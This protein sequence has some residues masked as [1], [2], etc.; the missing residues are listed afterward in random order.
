MIFVIEQTV[1]ETYQIE[2]NSEEEALA[3]LQDG[4][5]V[6]EPTHCDSVGLDVRERMPF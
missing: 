4:E 3:K 2:A 1:I 6:Y 5:R